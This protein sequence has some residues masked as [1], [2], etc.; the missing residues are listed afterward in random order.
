M[1]ATTSRLFLISSHPPS[2]SQTNSPIVQLGPLLQLPLPYYNPSQISSLFIPMSIFS[3]LSIIPKHLTPFS[4]TLPYSL[5]SLK[6]DIPDN[7]YNWIKTYIT[8][9]E[10][11][12]ITS[13]LAIHLL[14]PIAINASIVQGS[15]LG[16]TLFNI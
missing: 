8:S 16:P 1:Y 3:H 15:V 12:H 7:I 2:I 10:R 11:T 13:L 9:H 4:L 5:N 6:V 14:Q